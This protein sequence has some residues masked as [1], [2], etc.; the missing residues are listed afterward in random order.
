MWPMS[1]SSPRKR[2]TRKTSPAAA[3]PRK[4]GRPIGAGGAVTTAQDIFDCAFELAR[5]TPLQS[6]SMQLV[7]RALKITPALV[8]YYAGRRE[9]LTSKVMNAFYREACSSWP[10]ETP[11]WREDLIAACTLFRRRLVSRPGIAAYIVSNNKF[12]AFQLVDRG[13]IDY[14]AQFLER[15]VG[16][17]RRAEGGPQDTALHFHL[18][19]EFIA[20]TAHSLARVPSPEEHRRSLNQKL[21]DLDPR[22]F[23]NLH[24][25][26][27]SLVELRSDAA[28]IKGLNCLIDGLSV[29]LR[30]LAT[31]TPEGG[32]PG[33]RSSRATVAAY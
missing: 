12:R 8:H 22:Q 13:E 7:A 27:K 25:V 23:P 30:E 31:S 28:F 6:I 26:H 24:F 1:R 2:I 10:L 3:K 18:I 21:A 4:A 5:T 33:G 14:G 17:L 9:V 11:D 19:L 32:S 16:Y 15:F 29:S 20:G